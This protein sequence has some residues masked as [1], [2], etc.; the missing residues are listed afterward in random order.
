MNALVTHLRRSTSTRVL[1][2]AG[3]AW[4]LLAILGCA[5]PQ[6]GP[7]LTEPGRHCEPPLQSQTNPAQLQAASPVLEL[8]Q[9]TRMADCT[10][11]G[12]KQTESTKKKERR[13][14]NWRFR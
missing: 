12:S 14:S 3:V 9:G 7:T 4:G 5:T 11:V 10:P 8:A 1:L 6:S 13:N 2:T